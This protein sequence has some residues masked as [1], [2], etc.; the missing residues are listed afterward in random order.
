MFNNYTLKG[1]LENSSRVAKRKPSSSWLGLL[2]LFLMCFVTNTQA[3]T[4]LIGTGTGTSGGGDFSKG[5][6]FAANGWTV[7]N[8][9]VGAVKWAVG[10]AATGTNST[11]TTTTQATAA[12]GQGALSY[13]VTL[14]QPNPNITIGQLVG[15]T[16]IPPNT[17]VSNI[18]LAALTLTQAT[19]NTSAITSTLSFTGTGANLTT[20][21][22]YVSLDNGATNSSVT[23]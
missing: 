4:I 10:T 1:L 7:A 14:S 15:G 6:T 8:D 11:T 2:A 19:T 13:T 3:Q 22:A 21:S 17:Y 23:I 20:N 18:A 9:G 5:S 16:N 12:S